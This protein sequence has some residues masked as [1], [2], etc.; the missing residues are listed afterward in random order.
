MS[1]Y[2]Y[3]RGVQLTA[4]PPYAGT[5]FPDLPRSA[6][7]LPPVSWCHS[8]VTHYSFSKILMTT[9]L[10]VCYCKLVFISFIQ[11]IQT[12]CC[13]LNWKGTFG[14]VFLPILWTS[15]YI[16]IALPSAPPLRIAHGKPGEGRRLLPVSGF[17]SVRQ[18]R[19]LEDDCKFQLT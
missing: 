18:Y 15:P 6:V 19:R 2:R 8:K 9:N 16:L 1:P 11:A 7:Y 17:Y 10:R 5:E 12:P 3:F 4:G 14:E 13:A